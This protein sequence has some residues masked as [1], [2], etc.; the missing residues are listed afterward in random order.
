M[1]PANHGLEVPPGLSP[2]V[3]EEVIK[4]LSRR[5]LLTTLGV[6]AAGGALATVTYKDDANAA[7]TAS[8]AKKNDPEHAW[9]MVIDLRICDGCQSCTRSCQQRHE[10]REEQ[11]WI[12]VYSMTNTSGGTFAMPRPCMMC[13][14]P[15]CLKVCPVGAT[16]R[17]DEGLVLVDEDACVGSR[18]CMAAC[19]YEARYFNW[20]EPLPTKRLLPMAKSMPQ[21]PMQKKGTV[22]KCVLCADRLP[23]GE[24]PACVAGCPMGVLYIGDLVTDIAVNGPGTT[25]VLSEFLRANDAVRYKEELGTNPRVYYI[26]GHGQNLGGQA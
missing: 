13:E 6:A 11:T 21:M 5:N 2:K 17:T 23:Y 9:C 10:L 16:I 1:Q 24:L 20:T 7:T 12:K 3:K 25:V 18:A 14:D 4:V 26:L 22:G 8:A 19:P 15:P